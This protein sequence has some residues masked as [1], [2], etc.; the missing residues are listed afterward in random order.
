MSKRLL[1]IDNSYKYSEKTI[2]TI[3]LAGQCVS[4]AYRAQL[5]FWQNPGFV[6]KMQTVTVATPTADSSSCH[7]EKVHPQTDSM[8]QSNLWCNTAEATGV[9]LGVN[10]ALSHPSALPTAVCDHS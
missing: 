9:P 2:K 10:L 4:Q 8:G 5:K 1:H 6:L 3:S 7:K